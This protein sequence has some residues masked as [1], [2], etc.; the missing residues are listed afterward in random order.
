[1]INIQH[2]LL[3]FPLK[4][5]QYQTNIQENSMQTNMICNRLQLIQKKTEYLHLRDPPK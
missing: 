2:P 4:K 3:G 5:T 1:M